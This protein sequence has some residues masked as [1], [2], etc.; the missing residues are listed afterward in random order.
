MLD[1]LGEL[2]LMGEETNWWHTDFLF[3]FFDKGNVF[4]NNKFLLKVLNFNKQ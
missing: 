1:I 3:F 4:I 2:L